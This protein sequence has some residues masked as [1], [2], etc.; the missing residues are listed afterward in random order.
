MS[1]RKLQKFTFTKNKYAKANFYFAKAKKRE[2]LKKKSE[3]I[4]N[5]KKF[6]FKFWAEQIFLKIIIQRLDFAFLNA[7]A[8]IRLFHYA[9]KKIREQAERHL[10]PFPFILLHP[11]VQLVVRLFGLRLPY[12]LAGGFLLSLLLGL[13]GKWILAWHNS[14]IFCKNKANSLHYTHFVV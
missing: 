9:E 3:N 4:S 12:P 2:N 1:F 10:L 8:H 5:F 7:D 13:I 11:P 14:S 6:F